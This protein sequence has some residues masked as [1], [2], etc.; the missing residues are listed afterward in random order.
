M[1]IGTP[2]SK[3]TR[4]DNDSGNCFIIIKRR[5]GQQISIWG[6]LAS[7]LFIYVVENVEKVPESRKQEEFQ[8]RIKSICLF[9][10]NAFWSFINRKKNDTITFMLHVAAASRDAE[11]LWEDVFKNSFASDNFVFYVDQDFRYTLD[12]FSKKNTLFVFIILFST[13]FNYFRGYF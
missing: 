2:S 9:S 3:F 12:L 5:R 13:L 6:S 8:K 7:F 10:E 4:Q 11:N 1:V